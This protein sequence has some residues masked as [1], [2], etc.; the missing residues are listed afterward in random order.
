MLCVCE[1]LCL[2]AERLVRAM[3]IVGVIFLRREVL[4]MKKSRPLTNMSE[5]DD[6]AQTGARS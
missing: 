5:E 3:K 2:C 1:L 6:G 4:R